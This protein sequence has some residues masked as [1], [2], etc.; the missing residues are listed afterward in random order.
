M[1]LRGRGIRVGQQPGVG[2]AEVVVSLVLMAV[3]GTAASSVFLVQ[4]R[5]TDQVEKHGAARAASRSAMAVLMT[6]LRML[7]QGGGLEYATPTE[8]T[9]LAPFATAVVCSGTS[10]TVVS[11]L[12]GDPLAYDAAVTAEASYAGH[13]FRRRDT[14]SYVYRPRQAA[15]A[16]TT[17]TACTDARVHVFTAA[18]GGG[19]LVLNPGF[20]GASAG[21]PV[22]LYRRV[23]YQ[24]R[25]G[26]EF[27]GRVGLFR[28]AGTLLGE[29]IAGPLSDGASFRFYVGNA[30]QAVA[31]A[32]SDLA[33]VTGLQLVLDGLVERPARDGSRPSVPLTTSLFFWNRS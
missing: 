33:T 19:M 6:E 25:T 8:I 32:P 27:G 20:S 13:A 29:P 16:A 23:T 15:P 26:P 5:L 22:L 30:M 10:I 12:P 31:A 18:E 17:G 28:N 3:V 4:S 21:M 11:R 2:L 24:F 1:M 14:G 7:E 9:V